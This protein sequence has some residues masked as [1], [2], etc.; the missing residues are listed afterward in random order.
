MTQTIKNKEVVPKKLKNMFKDK[1]QMC[2]GCGFEH[3][4]EYQDCV[5]NK[6]I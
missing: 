2:F 6:S 4:D 1:K 3:N 5:W